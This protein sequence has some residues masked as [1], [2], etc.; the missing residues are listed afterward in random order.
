MLLY[1]Q[2]PLCLRGAWVGCVGGCF[3]TVTLWERGKHWQSFLRGTAKDEESHYAETIK[4]T[5]HLKFYGS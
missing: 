3:L 1:A 2:A 5:T 4:N